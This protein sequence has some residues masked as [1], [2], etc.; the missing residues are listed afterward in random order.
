MV[1]VH[2]LQTL[3]LAIQKFDETGNVKALDLEPLQAVCSRVIAADPL[4]LLAH[5]MLR[6]LEHAREMIALDE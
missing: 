3:V 2:D 1:H 5:E 6:L 4:Q